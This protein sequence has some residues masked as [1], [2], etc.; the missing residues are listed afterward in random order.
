MAANFR[1]R[2]LIVDD[3]ER[4]LMKLENLLENRGYDTVTAWGGKEALK[5]LRSTDFD[6]VL[7]DDFLPDIASEEILKAIRRLPIR[8][9]VILLEGLVSSAVRALSL[10]PWRQIVR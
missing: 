2:V 3:E 10:S 4:N 9:L 7:L 5:H 1:K 8:P 6:L